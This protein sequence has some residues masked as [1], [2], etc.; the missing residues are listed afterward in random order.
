M[1]VVQLEQTDR[2]AAPRR[3]VRT[4]TQHELFGVDV[5]AT[6]Y[7]DLVAWVVDRARRDEPAIVDFMCVHG[8]VHAHQHPQFK[9]VLNDFDVTATDGQPVRWALNLFHSAGLRE[10][11]Y[12]PETMWRTCRAAA[13][14]GVPVY[15]YG[16]SPD[17]IAK[18][19]E[20]LLKH[21]PALKIAGAESPPFRKLS[22]QE[23]AETCARIN[24]SGAK[25]VFI[26]IGCPKQEEFAWR[27]RRAI[28]GVQM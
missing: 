2:A 11:V 17:V 24:A 25:I 8:L 12:G 19:Q 18:L 27:N 9:Q 7:D 22:A 15:L 28:R 21:Y 20:N 13:D 23:E 16:S 6:K 3:A 26:G 1:A 14:A 5:S 10:R 4:P